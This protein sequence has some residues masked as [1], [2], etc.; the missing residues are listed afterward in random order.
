M[1]SNPHPAGAIVLIG[2][3]GHCRSV[4]DV[5]ELEGRFHVA[6]VVGLSAQRG[7]TMG[8]HTIEHDDD[9]LPDLISRYPNAVVTVGQ[10]KD[11]RPRVRLFQRIVELGGRPATV[12]SPTAVVSRHAVLG[13]GVTVLHHAVVN[14]GANIGDNC[15]L[16]T[17]CLV[18]H[19]AVI[20]SH[21]HLSTGSIV[22]GGGR[23]GERSF[24]GSGAVISHQTS[25]PEDSIVGAGRFIGPRSTI[26]KTGLEPRSETRPMTSGT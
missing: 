23:I 14:S 25:V 11:P 6:A 26:S 22:N 3:G 12:V 21:C 18:E 13:H 2:A 4:L 17:K 10:I 1:L 5:I 7:Q 15:I 20:G 16:N 9:D 19:D 24:I 8:D